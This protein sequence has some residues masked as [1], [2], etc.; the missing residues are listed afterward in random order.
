MSPFI[1]TDKAMQ[2][3]PSRP[4]CFYCRQPIGSEHK[5]DCVFIS[6]KVKVRVTIEYDIEV[7]AT[8]DVEMIEFHRNDASWCSNNIIPELDRLK[9]GDECL[10]HRTTTEYLGESSEPFLAE[11]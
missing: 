10:C 3:D 11:G 5:S 4:E 8:W 2:R 7:P 9:D 1:V 6:R